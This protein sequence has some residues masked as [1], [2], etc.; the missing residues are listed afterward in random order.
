MTEPFSSITDTF[1]GLNPPLQSHWQALRHPQCIIS[2][3]LS[4]L[5]LALY[6]KAACQHSVTH[7]GPQR[8]ATLPG[9]RRACP[10]TL[11]R[12]VA[13]HS[14]EEFVRHHRERERGDLSIADLACSRQC[15]TEVLLRAQDGG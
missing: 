8:I 6:R 7:T 15:S 4:F 12:L 11:L 13:Y 10:R 5:S 3:P 14:P 1:S 2:R 9:H